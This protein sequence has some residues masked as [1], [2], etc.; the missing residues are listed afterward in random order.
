[1]CEFTP[2]QINRA[3]TLKRVSD[4]LEASK[5]FFERKERRPFVLN[6]ANDHLSIKHTDIAC[7]QDVIIT[8]QFLLGLAI[9]QRSLS[10]DLVEEGMDE[11]AQAIIES[12]KPIYE[13]RTAQGS[14]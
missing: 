5:D 3:Q 7:S 6:F 14:R 2:Y 1:M 11:D 9:I 4:N 10:K 12:S 13:R 8:S